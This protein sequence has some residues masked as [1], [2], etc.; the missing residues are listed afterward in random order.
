M[1]D[2]VLASNS[3]DSITTLKKFMDYEFKIKDLSSL[4]YFLGIEVPRSPQGIHICQHKYTLYILA[5]SS[6]F[7]SKPLKVPTD[8]NLKLSK[9]KGDFSLMQLFIGG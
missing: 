6:T 3:L 8:Q 5:D 1:D 9:D 2:I 4:K 7:G